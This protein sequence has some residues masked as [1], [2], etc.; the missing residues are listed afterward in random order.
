MKSPY[1]LALISG[2]IAVFAFAPFGIAPVAWIAFVTLFVALEAERPVKGFF[3]GWVSGIIFYLGTVYWVVHSMYFYGGV[4]LNVS[5]AV[6]V[7]LATYLALYTALFGMFFSLTDTYGTMT[8]LLV[9]PSV[10]VS[11]EYLRGRLFTGFPWVLLGYS[12]ADYLSLIQIADVTGV[13]GVSFL[14]MT[15]NVLLFLYLSPAK[16]SV[17][18]LRRMGLPGRFHP[19]LKET[20]YTALILISALVYGNIRIDQVDS[21]SSKWPALKVG[22]VQ[23]NIEQS[24]KWDPTHAGRTVRTYL[25]LTERVLAEGAEMVVWPETAVPFYLETEKDLGPVVLDLPDRTGSYLLTGSPAYSYNIILGEYRSFNSAYLLKPGGALAER[26]DKVHL[27][28]F[29]EYVPL[30]RFLPFIDKLVVGVGDFAPGPGYFPLIFNGQGIGILI[31]YEA[32]FPEISRSFVTGGATILAN[33]TNDAWFGDTSAPYQHFQMA[34]LRAVEN[35]VFLIRAANTGISAILDPVGR[36]TVKS[37]LFT[38]ATLTA[39]VRLK[40]GP[41]GFYSR[42]G[43]F[44]PSLCIAVSC[45]FIISRFR[46]RARRD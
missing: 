17:P 22:I 28:P 13:W 18:L 43:D 2:F 31:C 34:V 29:G 44:F 45:I 25:G 27:V 9:V 40:Q 35:R 23:G 42:K 11:L 1:A 8:R 33:L 10:W 21:L 41:P 37:E 30:K 32:I 6:M 14:V 39:E 3:L 19:P 24:L 5:I 15:V 7:L 36:P 4:P 38:E 16:S 26:Y 12:Q 46:R 20:I